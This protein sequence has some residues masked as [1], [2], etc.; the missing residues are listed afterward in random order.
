ML[1]MMGAVWWVTAQGRRWNCRGAVLCWYTL[2]FHGVV[3]PSETLGALLV[4]NPGSPSL[5]FPGPPKTSS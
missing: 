1:W 2:P 5:P 3:G 4:Q